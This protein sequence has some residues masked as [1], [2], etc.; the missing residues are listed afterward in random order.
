[1]NGVNARSFGIGAASLLAGIF[2]AGSAVAGGLPERGRAAA[3]PHDRPCSV[4]ANVGITTDFVFRGISQ[5]N[6]EAA[7]QGGVDFNCGRFY[8]GGW[9]SSFEGI[10]SYGGSTWLN[11]YG[12]L[13]HTTGPITWDLGFIYY[14]FPGT[15]NWAGDLDNVELKLAASGDVWKG[16]KLGGVVYYAPDYSGVFGTAWTAEGTFAQILPQ[17]SFVTPIFSATVGRTFFSD[18][19]WG[20]YDLDYTY[21]NVGLTLAFHEKWAV[22]LRYWDTENE[23]L[24]ALANYFGGLADDRFVATLKYKF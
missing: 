20:Y 22:D 3:E 9:G 2:L 5:S 8:L 1:M 18:E 11:V 17:V 15:E 14:A 23:G 4:S 10:G 13:K 6:E 7:L 19:L 16:G 12:G 24:A 21:W